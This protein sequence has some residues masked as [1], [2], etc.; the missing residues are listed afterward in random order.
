MSNQLMEKDMETSI[1]LQGMYIGIINIIVRFLSA[2]PQHKV[3]A[4]P[5]MGKMKRLK[6]LSEFQRPA[7]D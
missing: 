4:K 3:V 1:V 5:R 7:N 2:G 6:D